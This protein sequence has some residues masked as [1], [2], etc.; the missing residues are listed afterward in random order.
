VVDL[1]ALLDLEGN[2]SVDAN[3]FVD[4]MHELREHAK[5]KLQTNIDSYKKIIYQHRRPKV[6]QEGELVMDH[7]RKER[8]PRGT[9]NKIKYTKIVP[10]QILKKISDN[11]Y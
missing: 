7:L 4:N 10:C 3:D 8:F 1:V 2:K 5:K 11:A 9:Y 6:F